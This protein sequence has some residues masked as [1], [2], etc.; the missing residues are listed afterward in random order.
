MMQVTVRKQTEAWALKVLPPVEQVRPGLWSIPV[1]IPNN[2]LRYVLV[3]AFELPDG[4]A[5]VDAGWDT[6]EAWDALNQGLAAT[7]HAVTDVKAVLVTHIHPD[8]Y[9]LAGRVREVS[10]A[11]I[12]MH[13]LEAAAIPDQHGD[14]AE[15][16]VQR[17]CRWLDRCGAPE[18][19][20]RALAEAS[21]E[22]RPYIHLAQ[23]DRLLTDGERLQLP[24]WSLEAVWTPGHTPGHLCFYERDYELLLSGDHVLPRIS[25][26]I[27]SHP[28]QGPN[29]LGDFLRSLDRLLTLPEQ[30][31]LPA[32]EYR[33]HGLAERVD[34]LRAHH[35]AR[36]DEVLKLLREHGSLSTWEVAERMT[37]SRSWGEFASLMRHAAVG[38]TRAH[39][40]LLESL[41]LIER[42]ESGR[43][44]RWTAG[45]VEK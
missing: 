12:G 5:L 15:R 4:V 41:G 20:A 37:W 28:M 9:G 10:G 24:G 32:H 11:W 34:E 14:A 21:A 19:E 42:V 18:E 44:E 40:V 43:E 26:N 22:L 30:E 45:V 2:P 25:P 17:S 23:P 6:P 39:L 3:Y 35:E 1:P 31:V 27:S 36:L 16:L 13:E 33:F 7:G 29:P 38:E 8:H